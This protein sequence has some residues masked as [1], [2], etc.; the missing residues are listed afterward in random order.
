MGSEEQLP[1]IAL[2]NNALY[3]EETFTDGVNGS[4]HRLTPVS[5]DGSPDSGRAVRFT[6][7]TQLMT[8]AGALPLSFEIDAGNLEEAL[9]KFPEAARDNLEQTIKRIEEMRREQASSL[10]VP[11][12]GGGPQGGGA[13]GG[14]PGGGMQMP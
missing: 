10:Y 5:S 8:S 3:Q 12:Q 4:I 2:D 11:G 7:H 1:E 6:G 13:P 9:Q 14:A